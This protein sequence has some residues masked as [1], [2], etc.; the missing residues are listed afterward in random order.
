MS[1]KKKALPLKSAWITTKEQHISPP[2]DVQ[3]P[4]QTPKSEW[5]MDTAP[6]HSITG[7]SE[8]INPFGKSISGKVAAIV[9]KDSVRQSTRKYVLIGAAGRAGE[10]VQIVES[11]VN[12][13]GN[14]LLSMDVLYSIN[15]KQKGTAA[16]DAPPVFNPDYRSTISIA[17]LLE[18]VNRYSKPWTMTPLTL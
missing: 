12:R 13:F 14:E 2:S 11:V 15:A 9:T 8:K 4:N 7:R 17:E 18:F 1:K 16:L 6:I 10:G 5:S 3:A